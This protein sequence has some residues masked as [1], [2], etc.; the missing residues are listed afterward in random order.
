MKRYAPVLLFA[1]IL[2]PA[3]QSGPKDA[4]VQNLEKL[5][6]A[7]DEV[8]PF[9]IDA[10][11]LLYATNQPGK[12]EIRISKRSSASAAWPQGKLF[13]DFLAHKDYSCRSP[14]AYR[15][16]TLFFAL[17]KVPDKKFEKL[18]NFD[19]VQSTGDRAPLPLLGIS[20]AEDELHPWVAA[21]GKEFYFS[22]KTKA[23]WKLFVANGPGA[24]AS[25]GPIGKAE[26]V[27]FDEGFHHATLTPSALIMY[28][29]G[30][31]KGDK[32]GIFRCKRA[33]LTAKWSDPEPVAALNTSD[34]EKG[35]LGPSLS[36][37]GSRLF[38]VSDRSGGKG[39]LD[40]Y[41]IAVKDLK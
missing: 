14:F 15:G 9:A 4:K 27:G 35:D 41:T 28:L 18:R 39:G 13:K 23:G 5:N 38:F 37:D 12:F 8:D 32:A 22:R 40:I 36:P 29:Q 19:L 30:P 3:A 7:A 10:S 16:T 33:S 6:T 26:A 11:S 34:G 20:E 31:L 24:G 1:L 2:A 21:G 17:D 25:L